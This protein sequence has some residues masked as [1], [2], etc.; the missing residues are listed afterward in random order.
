[1]VKLK[2]FYKAVN[3]SSSVQGSSKNLVSQAILLDYHNLNEKAMLAG[4]HDIKETLEIIEDMMK[5]YGVKPKIKFKSNIKGG[6][7]AT[8]DWLKNV[9]YVNKGI[10][11]TIKDFLMTVLHEL[12][13][14]VQA[15]REGGPKKF[16]KKY[17]TEQNMIAQGHI[18][19]KH[20]PYDD[21]KFEIEAEKFAEKNWK[22]WLKKL[23]M[24]SQM[25]VNVHKGK[26]Y[27]GK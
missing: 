27:K 2:D 22:Y 21:N 14:A 20:D 6:H 15:K 7:Y 11:K 13:H 18:P 26:H 9:M 10:N 4:R 12:F 16:E 25:R 24:K 8:Y 23:D 3:E 17:E 5:K 1:M 19:G